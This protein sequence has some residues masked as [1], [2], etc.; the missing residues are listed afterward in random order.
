MCAAVL[1][2]LVA[3]GGAA[4]VRAQGGLYETI[5][6]YVG[7]QLET[8]AVPGAVLVIVEGDEI[9]HVRGFGAAGPGREAPGPQTPFF[10]GSLSKAFTSLAVMQL[11][12]EGKVEL[13]AP[14]QRYLPWFT[15][16]DPQ[17][18][19]RITVRHLLNQTSGLS[20]VTGMLPL[21]DFD[22][23]ADAGERQGRA[24]ASYRPARPAGA[25]WEYS[26]MNFNL[27]GLIVEAV[28]GETYAGYVQE[29]IYAPLQMTHSYTVKAAA[30][31]DGLAVGHSVWFGFPLPVPDLAVPQG[32]LP[33]GQLI[34]SGEDVAHFLI[35]QLN[36][37]RY[38]G[39]SLLSPAGVALMQ[40]PAART[41]LAEVT[42][43]D[44]GM[45]WFVS[46][47][48]RGR[49][50]WHM[51]EV[52]DFF[53]YMTLLPEQKRGM[54]LLVNA[55]QQ[56]YTYAL[57]A[58]GEGVAALLAGDELPSNAWGVLP[59][60]LRALLLLPVAQAGSIVATLRTV[61]RWRS[62]ALARPGRVRLWLRYLL[63]PTLF[64]LALAALA[65][66]L[67]LMGLFR[68]MLFF[69]GDLVVVFTLSGLIALGW[70]CVRTPLLLRAG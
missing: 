27:L 46:D 45:G 19:A 26:N 39:H 48:A 6:A 11:V 44:Y 2:L 47:T 41:G 5:D 4:P 36:G 58:T 28:S 34:A 9:V 62:G 1:A 40:Q 3:W 18:A 25:E 17:A 16:A 54:V 21:T 29:H 20:Q 51:G 22:G 13:D 42:M 49:R 33:S 15:L 64:N 7:Q 56:M 38:A 23:A 59:W 35:S 63:L 70:L 60:A 31:Q 69:M 68:F 52:P 65:A 57:C 12:E 14:V 55:N 66:I 50:I 10:I 37:G 53:A 61:K 30:Q 32:S 67:P 24:L 8:L 43:G